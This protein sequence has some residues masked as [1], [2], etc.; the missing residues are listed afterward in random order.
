MALMNKIKRC[1]HC[2]TIL[3]TN[4]PNVAGYISPAVIEK[5]K[6]G[7]L[8]CN[9]CFEAESFTGSP[10]ESKYDTDYE[11]IIAKIKKDNALV[12]YVIDLFSFEGSLNSKLT[13]QLNG[14]DVLAVAN[15][16]DLM[17][18]E[19]NNVD[20]EEYVAHRFRMVGLKVRGV[21][22]TSTA[23][24]T[25]NID[26]MYKMILEY[27]NGRDVYFIGATT[28]GKSALISDLLKNFNNQTKEMI[29][30]YNFEDTKLQVIRIPIAKQHYIYEVPGTA[31]DN[32]LLSKV[33]RSVQNLITPKKAVLTRKFILGKGQYLGFGGL[34]LIQLIEGHHTKLCA[35]ASKNVDLYVR[36][37][38]PEK[39]FSKALETQIMKPSSEYLNDISEFDTYDIEVT[40]EKNRDIGISGLG[41]ISFI[42]N[43]QVFRIIVPK[44]VFVY[45]TRSKVKNVKY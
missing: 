28:S 14:I 3:Q 36:S 11:K 6:D 19:S 29:V 32:N 17:P 26:A 10:K 31:I 41:W 8:L 33:E 42:G 43:K 45:T 5:Y 34:A 38:N 24:E 12:V 27:A 21:V 16:R 13:M 15:K 40:E 20:L 9:H 23:D 35:Y 18:K 1:Y 30:R 4:N 39:F 7:L 22:I 37:G 44:G 2:G 25:F